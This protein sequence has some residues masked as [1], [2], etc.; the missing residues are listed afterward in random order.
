[1]TCS[2][3]KPFMTDADAPAFKRRL[4]V[5]RVDQRSSVW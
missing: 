3:T 1:M 4:F 2:G 5:L